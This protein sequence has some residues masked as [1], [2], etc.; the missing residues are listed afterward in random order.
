MIVY[1]IQKDDL[2]FILLFPVFYAALRFPQRIYLISLLV[3]IA[4]SIYVEYHLAGNF[5]STLKTIGLI[6]FMTIIFSEMSRRAIQSRKQA[7]NALKESEL[8][9]RTLFEDTLN[10]IMVVD[11]NKRFADANPA[12]CDFLETNKDNLIGQQVSKFTPLEKQDETKK[13]HTPFVSRRNIEVDYVVNGKTKTLLLNAVPVTINDITLLFSIG[14]DITERKQAVEKIRESERRFRELYEGSMNGFAMVDLN[15]KITRFNTSFMK[16]LGYSEEELLTKTFLDIT[17]ETWHEKE[18]RIIQEQVLKQGHS[19]LYEK[20]Y[21]RRDGTIIPIEIRTHLLKDEQGNPNGYWS[22]VRNVTQRKQTEEALHNSEALY[23]SL[24]E[25]LPQC[26]FRK[27]LDGKFNFANQRFCDELNKPY[28]AIIG[29][30][31]YDL[32]PANLAEKYQKDDHYVIETQQIFETVEEHQPSKKETLYVQVIKTPVYNAEGEIIGVQGI[33]WDITEK[34]RAE[35]AL[36]ES[37]ALIKK[38]QEVANI[39][40]WQTNLQTGKLTWSNEIFEVFDMEK[41]QFNGKRETFYNHIHPEDRE[42]VEAALQESIENDKL[43]RIEHRIV[44][45]DGSIRWVNELAEIFRDEEGNPIQVIGTVQDITE[46]KHLEEQLR[47]SQK[48][49]AVGQMA[50]GIA[51]D[52]NNLLMAIIGYSE[53]AMNSLQYDDVTL[54]NIKEINK[55]GE[56]AASLTRQLLAFSRKQVLKP[57]ILN[58]N[59]LIVD[60]DKMLRRLI[61]EDIE[62]VIKQNA[63]LGR[64]K[65]DPGQIEQVVLNLV[66]N[67]RDAMPQGGKLTIETKKVELDETYASTHP[68]VQPGPYVMLG[69][70]DNGLG[71]DKETQERIFEPFFTTKQ[72]GKGTGLGLSTVYGIVKQ[73]GGNIYVYS[74]PNKSTTF[75]VYLPRIEDEAD[76]IKERREFTELSGSETVLLVED[77]D[78]VL[79]MVTSTLQKAGYQVLSA[80]N[81]TEAI[82]RWEIYVNPIQLLLTDVV[83]PEMSGRELSNR[84][85]SLNPDLKVIYMSGYTDDAIVHHGILDSGIVYLQKPF[86]PNVLLEKIRKVLDSS[87]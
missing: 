38:A 11:E 46:R 26:I 57:K 23:Q 53:M 1:W 56:R 47:Q 65:A 30:T 81:G 87:G 3:C 13:G 24:V 69:I 16:I 14:Y 6:S 48:M 84:L 68:S 10:P 62:F 83:M 29:K 73:S 41:E 39:G 60:M 80:K 7:E 34:K 72:K 64:V 70:S 20:E 15:G 54:K 51:H 4:V 71:M 25:N 40:F 9:L 22:F 27:D 32:F 61:G 2:L 49:E 43:Y 31:D 52:F 76:I 36:Q 79:E 45:P 5:I 66:L 75:K 58:L 35:K 17:P 86:T 19:G 82:Q 55:A 37:H 21:I 85:T 12:A 42:K 50:G 77:E 8:K 33:F 28:E 63:T 74:E 78:L 44:R 67:A 18:Q 59:T